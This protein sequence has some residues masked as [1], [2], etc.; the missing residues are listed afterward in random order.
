M[1]IINLPR[2]YGKTTRL[3]YASEF[4][5]AP[6]L[7]VSQ[8]HKQRLLDRA[9]ELNLAIP[10]P[11][12]PSDVINGGVFKTGLR[13]TDIFIDDAQAVLRYLLSGLGMTGNI[14]AITITDEEDTK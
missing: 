5:N 9:K 7:C 11:I 4:N 10:E 6:I 13:D 14:K 1:K 2:G 12:T 8:H 3:L